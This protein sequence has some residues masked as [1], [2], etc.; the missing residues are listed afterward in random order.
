MGGLVQANVPADKKEEFPS[1]LSWISPEEVSIFE[2]DNGEIRCIQDEDGI[3][4]DNYLNKAYK[5]NS[6]EYLSLLNYYQAE[7]CKQLIAKMMDTDVEG[8]FYWEPQAP[9]GYNGGYNLGCFDNDAPTVA[10]D[11]FKSK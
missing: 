4:E 1:H 11:A 9:N 8:I 10:L 5:K 2:L 7:T 6:N 3:I